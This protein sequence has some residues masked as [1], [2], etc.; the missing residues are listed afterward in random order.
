MSATAHLWI[1]EDV[2][3]SEVLNA[4][5]PHPELGYFHGWADPKQQL[6]MTAS[7]HARLVSLRRIT[8]LRLMKVSLSVLYHTLWKS[9]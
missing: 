9:L 1:E 5:N 8:A 7:L 4:V 3:N 2:N 6:G